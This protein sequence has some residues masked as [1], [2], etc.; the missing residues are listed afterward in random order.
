VARGIAARAANGLTFRGFP[1]IVEILNRIPDGE[2]DD[3][4]HQQ[5]IN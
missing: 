3:K 4:G 2:G 1:Q 5:D